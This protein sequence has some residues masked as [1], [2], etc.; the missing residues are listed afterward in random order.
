MSFERAWNGRKHEDHGRKVYEDSLTGRYRPAQ[1]LIMGD[2]FVRRLKE[3]EINTHGFYNNLNFDYRTCHIHWH[4]V[5]GREVPDI[6]YCDL[7]EVERIK[8]DLVFI[9]AGTNDLARA[10]AGPEE[11]ADEVYELANDVLGLGVKD[12]VIGQ[13]IFRKG[14]GIPRRVPKYNDKV[15]VNN[16]TVIF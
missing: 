5:G 15:V 8:P 3:Y 12:V 11:V 1:V 14:R 6:R 2:S 16:W 7:K 9:Q 13:T 4:G 10:D